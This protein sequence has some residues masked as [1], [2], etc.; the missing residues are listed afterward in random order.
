MRNLHIASLLVL[1]GIPAL[2]QINQI[3]QTPKGIFVTVG[4]EVPYDFTYRLSRK[5]AGEK[6]FSPIGN[7]IVPKSK[8][9][10]TNRI[11]H[12]QKTFPQLPSPNE[13]QIDRIWNLI[14]A[15]KGQ[16]NLFIL[17]FAIER[18][19]LGLAL[20]DSNVVKGKKYD[21]RI[22]KI[23][24]D[25]VIASVDLGGIFFDP[26]KE[27]A[28]PRAIFHKHKFLN[29][30]LSLQW[31]F[32]EKGAIGGFEIYRRDNL[33]GDFYPVKIPA[34]YA[35]NRDTTFVFVND[36]LA[37]HYEVYEYKLRPYD[38]LGNQGAFTAATKVNTFTSADLPF[39]RKFKAVART[40][41][42]IKLSWKIDFK[43]F[44]RNIQITRSVSFDSG[45]VTIAEVSPRDSTYTDVL[46]KSM[47]NYYYRLVI[48]GPDGITVPTS[49]TFVLYESK[50]KPEP[51]QNVSSRSV[52]RGIELSWE[53]LQRNVFGYYIFRRE[54]NED[55][56]QI[57]DPVTINPKGQYHYV[58]TTLTLRGDR[59]YEYAIK[60]ISDSYVLSQFSDT[61]TVRPNI[62]V[63]I[64][65]PQNFRGRQA[66]N[67]VYL[68]WDDMTDQNLM[69]YKVFRKKTFESE[70]KMLHDS[71]LT[72]GTNHFVDSSMEKGYAYHYAVQAFSFFGS[73]SSI[74]QPL[75]F[76]FY[77]NLP[78]P[79][80]G[81]KAHK[82]NEG[83]RV[84]WGDVLASDLEGFNLYRYSTGSNPTRI[85]TVAA[86]RHD[87]VDPHVER[88]QLYFYYVTSSNK[89]E[90]EGRP[91]EAV[92]VRY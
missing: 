58:D 84:V 81:V 68:F 37:K 8:A 20:L 9:E 18:L 29:D 26:P 59:M 69:G 64:Q 63:P 38:L 11:R 16:E 72:A 87:F 7:G 13:N 70:F 75:Q 24:S 12:F 85:T 60:A 48:H 43:P 41:R 6:S 23:K 45:F 33:K 31:I 92:S 4:S 90:I 44:I 86:N 42:E 5:I 2:A 55:F 39:L 17:H 79:P 56:I 3:H 15:K 25:K 62:E 34:G 78:T 88:G 77:L 53:D 49:S 57:S 73:K 91:S 1:L 22:E 19:S 74:S 80:S 35:H 14:N 30:K 71:L 54:K 61:V 27:V 32:R 83:I 46:P 47:E 40:N 21:Y 50:L 66:D 52:R 51:P 28:L 65:A 67:K 36:T 76:K 89:Q 10:Y 82:V